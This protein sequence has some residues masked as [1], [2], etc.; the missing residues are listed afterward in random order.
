MSTNKQVRTTRSRDDVRDLALRG[1]SS[2]FV[3]ALHKRAIHD[4]PYPLVV[5]LV[6]GEE[7]IDVILCHQGLERERAAST[8][9]GHL[10]RS[11]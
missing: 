3:V 7:N 10:L 4:W 5:V 2:S 9:G 1:T 6:A 8:V 11:K